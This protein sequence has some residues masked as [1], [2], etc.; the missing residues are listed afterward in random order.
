MRDKE[1]EVVSEEEEGEVTVVS[2]AVAGMHGGGVF[3][4]IYY[5]I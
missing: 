1:G 3:I 2:K 4:I 5:D